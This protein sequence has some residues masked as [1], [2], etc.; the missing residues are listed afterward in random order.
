MRTTATSR[1]PDVSPE[2]DRTKWSHERAEQNAKTYGLK[3]AAYSPKPDEPQTDAQIF[4]HIDQLTPEQLWCYEKAELA[5]SPLYTRAEMQVAIT[6]ARISQTIKVR[7][8]LNPFESLI[9]FLVKDLHGKI[10]EAEEYLE[11]NAIRIKLS[12]DGA[13]LVLI[14][15]RLDYACK[16]IQ[17]FA[18]VLHEFEDQWKAIDRQ[19][20]RLQQSITPDL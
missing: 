2:T 14:N 8:S 13:R 19:T 1:I 15:Q 11:K 5:K 20:K 9:R 16:Y 6:L 12:G 3:F 7:N 10:V 18:D 17:Q 4:K